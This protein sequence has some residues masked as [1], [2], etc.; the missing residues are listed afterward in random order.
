MFNLADDSILTCR[1]HAV[2]RTVIKIGLSLVLAMPLGCMASDPASPATGPAPVTLTARRAV[3]APVFAQ[4]PAVSPDGR[5]V[6]FSWLGDI[7]AVDA[8]GGNPFRLTVHPAVER[9][10]VFSPDGRTL[11]FESE[12]EGTRNIYTMTLERTSAGAYV[13]GPV[14]AV[15]SLDRPLALSGWSPDGTSILFASTLEPSIY[16]GTRMFR[17]PAEGGPITRLTDAFG[18]SPRLSP[19]GST[20]TFTRGRMDWTRPRYTGSGTSSLWTLNL[21]TGDFTPLTTDVYNA[22]EGFIRPDGSIVYLS[23]RGGTNGVWM[24]PPGADDTRAVRL[25][26][27]EPEPGKPTIGH[28]VRDLSVNTTGTHAVFA[29]WDRLFT[30]D[31]R[32]PGAAPVE[33]KVT[34]TADS[35][36]LDT[37]RLDVSREVSEVALSPDGKTVAMVARGEI[38]VRSTEDGRPTRRV[39]FTH[40]RE[41]GIAWSPDNRVLWFTSDEEGPS[42]IYYATVS[43]SRED[44]S[45]TPPV[46]ARDE[47]QPRPADGAASEPAGDVPASDSKPEGEAPRTEPMASRRTDFGKRWSESIRFEIHRLDTSMVPKGP[48]DGVLGMELSSPIPSPDGRQLLVTRGLG[49]LV[50]IDLMDRNA[51]VL[52]EGWSNPDPKWASDSRHIVFAR[53]DLDFNSDIFLLDTALN[54][55]GTPRQPVNLSRHPDNDFSPWL[56]VDG[57]VL[58]YLSERDGDRGAGYE[59]YQVFLDRKLDGLRPYELDEYFKRA[60]E[61][62]RR[63]RVIDPVIWDEPARAENAPRQQQGADTPAEAAGAE[64][65]GAVGEPARAD[66]GDD[67][68]SETARPAARRPRRPEPLTFDADDAWLRVRRLTTTLGSKSNLAAT[69]AGDRVIFSAPAE[70][71][72]SLYS[73]TYKGDG[74]TVLQ[75]GAVSGVDVSLTGDKVTFIRAGTASAVAPG[76]GRAETFAIDA[77]IVIDTATQQ[78]R[79]FMEAS[80]VIG[81]GFYHPTLKGL[82]W[83]ALT[84]H[85]A[86]LAEITRTPEE[87]DRAFGLLLGELDGSHLGISSRSSV[88]GPSMQTGYLGVDVAPAP[89]GY[90]VTAVYEGGPADR[91][92]SRIAVGDLITSVEGRALAEGE[93]MPT[94]EFYSAFAGRSG[95]ETLVELRHDDAARPTRILIVPI[96]SGA[97]T[98]LRYRAEVRRRTS[99][100]DQLSGGRLGYLHIRSM[101]EP[102]VR[103]FE[104]DLFAVADGKEGLIIDVRDNG[105]GSTADI[106]LASLTAPNHAKTQPRGV[107]PED[108]PFDA[109]PRDRRLIYAYVRPI[110]VLINEN[111]FSNAEIFA[112]AIRSI[113]RGKLVGTATFGGVISTGSATLIDGSTI[114]T[115]FRGWYLPDGT[116]MEN[117]GA[118]PHPGLDIPQRPDDEAAGVDRQ[119]EAAVKELLERTAADP[120]LHSPSSTRVTAPADG[121]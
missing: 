82:D 3:D 88:R 45:P 98:D 77:P 41:R 72:R 108:V 28:G 66:R 46:P 33:V 2:R 86:T 40:G 50:L 101:S 24:I 35:A 56:S 11:A 74:R 27:F 91:P 84:S 60:G 106:L 95:R 57:K 43:L 30:L 16:R 120:R 58:Y 63:R 18:A 20:L 61:A 23:S 64:P 37:E 17:V 105:G 89:G 76:G 49:D 70:T 65:N 7:W 83:P 96:G 87:F 94:V 21:G 19:D 47:R 15:T 1:R 51:R 97:D 92:T 53:S 26:S 116:D 67:R 9:R 31:L 6:V 99:L 62:A 93:A 121:R 55:D 52:F 79:K 8:T 12:R 59:V 117:N 10:A 14:R 25:A 78:R 114:R 102:S 113:G 110:S 81:N 103:D 75:A 73:I 115:P 119:L 80:R 100:V 36:F 111:S 38:F 109:Y 68:P 39:T 69:P 71:E 29:V 44:L 4:H 107:L 34:A 42:A 104:R 5:T 112:H 32:T 54:A 90:R 118:R 13:T 85:Y 22:G 48:N